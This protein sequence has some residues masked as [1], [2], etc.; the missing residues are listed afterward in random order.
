MDDLKYKLRIERELTRRV[1]TEQIGELLKSPLMQA[2]ITWIIVETLQAHLGYGSISGTV[3]EA[4][5][6]VRMFDIEK[7]TSDI[8]K[9]AESLAPLSALLVK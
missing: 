5:T 9:L 4:G 3:L 1:Q 2:L 6:M 8:S 7:T